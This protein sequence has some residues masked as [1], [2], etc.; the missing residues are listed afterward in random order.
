MS[1]PPEIHVLEDETS[2]ANEVADFLAWTVEDTLRRHAQFR[3]VLSGGSTPRALYR[4]LVRP[5]WSQRI[6]WP[7]IRFFFG[8]ERCVPPSHAESNYATAKASLFDPLGIPDT[9]VARMHGEEPHEDAAHRYESAIRQEFTVDPTTVP[10]FDLVLLGLGDDGHTASLFPG[11]AAL[12]ERTRLVV[13]GS[14]PTGVPQRVTMTYPLLN[15]AK[16]VAFL[17][18]GAKKAAMVHRILDEGGGQPMLPAARIQPTE[19]RLLWYLDEAA[20]AALTVSR[21]SVPHH[22]E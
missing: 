20:A 21:R 8:D 22:E 16:V 7:R 19:G 2:L 6:A 1:R 18:T 12:E 5:E 3:L 15:R 9:Q 13:S 11:T 14:S 17:V 4:T 10:Q